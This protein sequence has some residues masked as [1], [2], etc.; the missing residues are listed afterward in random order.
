MLNCICSTYDW[1]IESDFA[2][3]MLISNVQSNYIPITNPVDEIFNATLI[4]FHFPNSTSFHTNKQI[5]Q[6][7]HMANRHC[8]SLMVNLV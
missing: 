8:V 3:T 5:A 1:V 6:N 4:Y 7:S 2:N